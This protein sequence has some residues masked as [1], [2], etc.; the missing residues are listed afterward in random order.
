MPGLRADLQRP[1]CYLGCSTQAKGL[2]LRW[3]VAGGG[4]STWGQGR[5]CRGSLGQCSVAWREPHALGNF[6]GRE[7]GAAVLK[8]RLF[9]HD[10]ILAC[11]LVEVTTVILMRSQQNH[12]TPNGFRGCWEEK[13]HAQDS[14]VSF[15]GSVRDSFR[16]GFLLTQLLYVS[17]LYKAQVDCVVGRRTLV[18]TPEE[19]SHCQ[20]LAGELRGGESCGG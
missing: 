20:L 11:I 6:F 1:S 19:T 17:S 16:A 13:Q 5:P 15:D 3:A 10:N 2:L 12:L 8:N 4:M 9:P 18:W 14:T 7:E